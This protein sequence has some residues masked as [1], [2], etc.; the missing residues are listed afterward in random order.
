MDTTVKNDTAIDLTFKIEGMTCASCVARVEKA[1]NAVPG[2]RSASINLATEKASV[3]A[4]AGTG[5]D[6]LTA[7]VEKAGYAVKEEEIALSIAGMT[8]ASYVARVFPSAV[9]LH[10]ERAP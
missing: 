6:A 3:Q 9:K 1:L 2:V 7:A 4:D 8:C 5:V 10:V